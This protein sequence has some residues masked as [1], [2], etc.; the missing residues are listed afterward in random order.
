MERVKQ[1]PPHTLEIFF[2]F[3]IPGDLMVFLK[4]IKIVKKNNLKTVK[5][6]VLVH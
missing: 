1:G 6:A 5:L 3:W 2:F 4:A